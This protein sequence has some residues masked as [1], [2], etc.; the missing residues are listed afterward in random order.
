MVYKILALLGMAVLY[1]CYF[2]RIIVRKMHGNTTV[3]SEKIKSYL[4]WILKF[5]IYLMPIVELVSVYMVNGNLIQK[6]FGLYLVI[7][8]DTV[9][10]IAAVTGGDNLRDGIYRYSRNPEFLGFDLVYLGIL[11]MFFNPVLLIITLAAIV[12]IHLRILAKEHYMEETYGEQYLNYRNETSRY[13]GMGRISW[14]KIIIYAYALIFVW[15]VLYFFTCLVYAGPGLSFIWLWSFLALFS[16]GRIRM[17]IKKMRGKRKI[18]VAVTVVFRSIVAVGLIVFVIVESLIIGDMTQTSD[19]EL[20]YVIVLG[21]G[22]RGTEPLNPL[23][24][25]IDK[26]YE[27]MS[28]HENTVLIASGGQGRGE[29]ISEA[30]CIRD[31]LVERGIDSSRILLEDRSTSTEENLEYS[32][33][34]IG[35]PNARIGIITNGFHEY[36][37]RLYAKHAGFTDIT[38]V[39]AITLFPVGIHYTVREFF[40]VVWY[41]ITG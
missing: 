28:E 30:Q 15:S 35:D 14:S 6:I 18:P 19:T 10:A 16:E 25:R 3:Q 41:M 33:K 2:G 8:G 37:A 22:L 32:L 36:R 1:A 20:E 5:I 26:A 4:D 40:G 17:L 24:V 29:M 11:V 7:I 23:R 12:I 13:A 39:P 9:F 31:K 21:A 27:Y 34:V 38:S